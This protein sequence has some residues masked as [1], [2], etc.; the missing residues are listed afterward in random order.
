LNPAT[1]PKEPSVKGTRK[2]TEHLT[3]KTQFQKDCE[4]EGYC[5]WANCHCVFKEAV[6]KAQAI[7]KDTQFR[8]QDSV[9]WIEALA[10]ALYAQEK[11][12][13][14]NK[15]EENKASSRS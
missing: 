13:E 11:K 6:R 14:E 10:T 9:A 7:L 2:G 15:N 8:A 5:A 12:I 3:T 1:T 4:D